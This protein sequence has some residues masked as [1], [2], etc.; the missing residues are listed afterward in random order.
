M[1]TK[2]SPTLWS[3]D[4]GVRKTPVLGE[5]QIGAERIRPGKRRGFML[6]HDRLHG[7]HELTDI[8][9]ISL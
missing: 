2:E 9:G 7:G 1:K 3:Q 6:L 4:I 5:P 8:P